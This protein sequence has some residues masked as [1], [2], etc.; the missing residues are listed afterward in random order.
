L[1]KI[2]TAI[3]NIEIR[4]SGW[5]SF[6]NRAGIFGSSTKSSPVNAD[7]RLEEKSI[8]K[9]FGGIAFTTHNK[10]LFEDCSDFAFI[11]FFD[12]IECGSG[13]QRASQRCG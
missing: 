8:G 7:K 12:P 9:S 1:L 3:C 2:K 10:N 11:L 6:G 4:R 13:N 5:V